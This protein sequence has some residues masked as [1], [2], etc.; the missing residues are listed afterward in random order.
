MMRRCC[1]MRRKIRFKKKK[2]FVHYWVKYCGGAVLS[3]GFER[4]VVFTHSQVL[5]LD[6]QGRG[7]SLRSHLI[8]SA[9]AVKLCY[10]SYRSEARS[11]QSHS[12]RGPRHIPVPCRGGWW[13]G[14]TGLVNILPVTPVV[15][16]GFHQVSAVAWANS[17]CAQ[18]MSRFATGGSNRNMP[19]LR[20]VSH[21]IYLS[22]CGG[23]RCLDHPPSPHTHTLSVI[24][25]QCFHC[26]LVVPESSG[27]HHPS[28]WQLKNLSESTLWYPDLFS[29]WPGFKVS[30]AAP[31]FSTTHLVF[32][33][34][35]HCYGPHYWIN[36]Y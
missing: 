4:P 11:K 19:S 36:S 22:G 7:S 6:L 18:R 25:K 2:P 28:G 21:L 33:N 10:R 31:W 15:L 32:R 20:R 16:R 9:G 12:W 29:L 27:N 23:C 17:R 35:S 34:D 1:L 26:N 5:V 3:C 14:P 30:I 8:I 24:N 13:F